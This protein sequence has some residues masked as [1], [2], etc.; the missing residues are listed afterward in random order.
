MTV[1]PAVHAAGYVQTGRYRIRGAVMR[2]VTSH[3]AVLSVQ[4]SQLTH[5]GVDGAGIRARLTRSALS[6]TL[7]MMPI[8]ALDHRC[9]TEL[10]G[11]QR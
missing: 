5:D 4:S 9:L 8:R 6:P 7:Q 1:K 3:A 2:T 10:R 11:D